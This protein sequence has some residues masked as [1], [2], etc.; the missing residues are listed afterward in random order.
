MP[1]PLILACLWALVACL[2]AM[3]PQ[4]YHWPAAWALIATGIP[5]LGYATLILG[6]VWGFLLLAAGASVLRYP[7]IRALDR[8]R[9]ALRAKAPEPPGGAASRPQEE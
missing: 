6:P 9:D 8:L 5:I 1:L 2:V 4:R 7:L 3:G